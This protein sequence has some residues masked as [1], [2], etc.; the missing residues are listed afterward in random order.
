MTELKRLRK[1]HK[2]TQTEI[3]KML[4]VSVAAYN[5]YENGNRN[6]PRIVVKKIAKIFGADVSHIFLP[7]TFTVSKTKESA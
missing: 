7:V 3:A 1:Q 5:M 2:L 6:V 4:G